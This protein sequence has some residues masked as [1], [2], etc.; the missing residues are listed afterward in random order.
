MA[1]QVT[2]QI[3]GRSYLYHV[4]SAVDPES[5]KR[6]NRW[7]YL[8]RDVSAGAGGAVERK[9]AA[10][11]GDARRR[12]LDALEALLAERDYAEVTADAVA[13]R[14]GLAHGT[15][16]RHFKDKRAALVAALE[17]VSE[18]RRPMFEALIAEPPR[19]DAEARAGLRELFA[20]VLRAPN[21]HPALQRAWLLLVERDPS[22]AEE[23]RARRAHGVQKLAN[24]F[25][26]LDAAGFADLADPESTTSALLAMIEGFHR[27]SV[28]DRVPL[29]AARL[30]A[31]VTIA[32]RAVFGAPPRR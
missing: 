27:A 18:R 32:E 12:L 17:R 22:F 21:E 26:T 15:F 5:G 14:A 2:K 28:I 30:E 4:E 25:R 10:P 11:R 8:G 13:V 19:S 9:A 31:A 24:Y 23:R 29:D 7:T 3:G 6:R 1:Y 16:Y 20:A